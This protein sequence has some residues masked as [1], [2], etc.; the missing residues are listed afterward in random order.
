MGRRLSARGRSPH[1]A[2]VLLAAGALCV[3]LASAAAGQGIWDEPAFALYRQ[4]LEALGAKDYPKAASLAR[5]A[6]VAYPGHVL[7]FYLWGQ[8]ALAQSQWQEAA[9]ALGKVVALY[10]EAAAAHRDLG[11][12]CQQ[13][14]HIE[15]AARSYEAALAIRPTDQESRARLAIMLMNADQPGRARD[16]LKTLAD[17][18]TKLPDVYVAL[19]RMAYDESDFPAAAANFEKAVTL[20]GSGRIWLNLGVVRAKMGNK[21][22][23]MQAFERASQDAD[24]KEQAAKE[25]ERLKAG[26]P[27]APRSSRPGLPR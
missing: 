11:S 9:D 15:D 2:G 21:A 24:T 19:G 16:H 6:T 23:A 26:P 13:L 25:I 12:A 4:G 7:A 8:A 3:L 5:E 10:P 1:R 22:G 17:A 20:R 27:P 14:G 18:S